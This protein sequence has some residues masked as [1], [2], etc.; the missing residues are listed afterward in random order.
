M[1][2]RLKNEQIKSNYILEL[3]KSRGITDVDRFLNPTFKDVNSCY[4]LENIYKG[5]DL[6]TDLK[7]D[8]RIGL[9]VD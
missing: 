2:V 8:A 1:K 4:D 3:L 7:P 5:I 9:V 6:I